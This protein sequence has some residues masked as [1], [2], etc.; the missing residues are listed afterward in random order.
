M[1]SVEK[2]WND[3]K[4]NLL[5]FIK[6][7]VDYDDAEDI[8]QDVFTKVI[9]QIESL[10]DHSKLKN[11]IFKITRNTIIDYYRTRKEFEIIPEWLQEEN[12]ED[13][14]AYKELYSCLS[15]MINQLPIKYKNALNA[16]EFEGKSQIDI[17]E[18][19]QISIS[20]TKSRVQ[21]AR[22]YLKNLFYDCCTVENRNGIEVISC[23]N[24]KS[25]CNSC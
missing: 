25:N 7:R 16:F 5:N 2:I 23:D 20:A 8:L 9:L 1:G 17:S 11:W 24:Q 14:N 22:K 15:P 3:Y 18:L 13:T 19:E 21:R 6:K 10:K 12:E 4:I